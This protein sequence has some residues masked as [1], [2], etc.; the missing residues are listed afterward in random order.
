M[1]NAAKALQMAAGILISVLVLGLLVYA[2]NNLAKTKKIEQQN[3]REEQAA[4]FNKSFEAYHRDLVGTELIALANKVDDYNTKYKVSEGY[5]AITVDINGIIISEY[6]NYGKVTQ[7]LT[8]NNINVGKRID[9]IAKDTESGT[10]GRTYKYS[11]LSKLTNTKLRNIGIADR[12][13]N[14]KLNEYE[15]LVSERKN[16]ARE[17]FKCT[18]WNYDNTTGRITEIT[19]EKI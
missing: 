14:N 3:V 1:E 16:F 13:T 19:F 10:D 12:T 5:K 18:Q 11:E 6:P 4:D 15:R 9:E 7:T 2:Y 8:Q 17:K